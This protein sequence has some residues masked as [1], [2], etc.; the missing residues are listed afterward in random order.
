MAPTPGH[1][2][3]PNAPTEPAGAS[4]ARTATYADAMATSTATSRTKSSHGLLLHRPMIPSANGYSSSRTHTL[5]SSPPAAPAT[6]ANA[7]PKAA[8]L[9]PAAAP[10]TC[11][12]DQPKAT[13]LPAAAPMA[14]TFT[15]ITSTV[16]TSSGA[17]CTSYSSANL[18]LAAAP[19]LADTGFDALEADE[20][21]QAVQHGRRVHA[22]GAD[23]VEL[24]VAAPVQQRE[25]RP[26]DLHHAAHL[27]HGDADEQVHRVGLE[28]LL[29]VEL[30]AG[31]PHQREEVVG[32]D[33]GRRD[34]VDGHV[35]VGDA[36]HGVEPPAGQ[37]RA[38]AG[39]E[40]V[41]GAPRPAQD[42]VQPL[43]EVDGRRAAERVGLH[44]AVHGP[45]PLAVQ[46]EAGHHVLRRDV[47]HPPDA[48]APLRPV[49]VRAGRHVGELRREPLVDR[50][51]DR[52]P[53]LVR[54]QWQGVDEGH[55]AAEPR[56]GAVQ[57]LGGGAA[58]GL[59][60]G[61]VGAVER[62]AAE[63]A[64]GADVRGALVAVEAEQGGVEEDAVVVAVPV[65]GVHVVE[66]LREL[67]EGRV[68]AVARVEHEAHGGAERPRVVDVVV[69]V[70]VDDEGRVGEQ[71]RD[72]QLHVHGAG[73]LLVVVPRPLLARDVHQHREPHVDGAQVQRAGGARRRAELRL[74]PGM[75]QH[76]LNDRRVLP[77]LVVFSRLNPGA[78]PVRPIGH[79][80]RTGTAASVF[81]VAT[82]V[83]LRRPL[84]NG[85]EQRVHTRLELL[86]L[87]A[88]APA[89]VDELPRRVPGVRR[90]R[91]RREV[92]L[93]RPWLHA[94]LPAERRPQ[95]GEPGRF[96][97]RLVVDKRPAVVGE[98]GRV[99]VHRVV[100]GEDGQDGVHGAEHGLV[101]GVHGVDEH[102][103]AREL[104]GAAT[105]TATGRIVVLVEE[106]EVGDAPDGVELRG[107]VQQPADAEPEVADHRDPP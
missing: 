85:G 15:A 87:L 31:E 53:F 96:Q 20:P 102:V 23:H 13:A 58:V 6:C 22:R 7:H 46:P 48:V 63:H 81:G 73:L 9:V 54:G 56:A 66:A 84:G 42:L 52:R 103:D 11:A 82:A 37:E 64:A 3:G 36:L 59:P 91:L 28:R 86:V 8:T 45:P 39:A 104:A 80:R 77:F 32:E 97:Q 90:V 25:P 43:R 107:L 21:E 88:N 101:H 14:A 68:V 40:H 105:A 93:G 44:C 41:E 62:G 67:D 17:H 30:A 71:R 70:E 34:G 5:N 29:D 69:A 24:L 10:A 2:P 38:V 89:V 51:R 27:H 74:V 60:P 65:R 16:G 72:A 47:V 100:C 12:N 61:R 95:R 92:A 19:P 4:T 57:E 76:D 99:P 26:L 79:V 35:G 49:L 33:E 106:R 50:R 98:V 55:G 18:S 1:P 94:V 83:R 78:R 75:V